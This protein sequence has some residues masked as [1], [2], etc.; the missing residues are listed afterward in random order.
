MADTN[1]IIVSLVSTAIIIFIVICCS[2]AYAVAKIAIKR[3]LEARSSRNVVPKPMLTNTSRK[4]FKFH[5][6]LLKINQIFIFSD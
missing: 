1:A 2:Y 3:K 4:N 5:L 6:F